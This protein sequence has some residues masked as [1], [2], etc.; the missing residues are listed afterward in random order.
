MALTLEDLETPTRKTARQEELYKQAH[1]QTNY[2]GYDV[3]NAPC[4]G[5][6]TARGTAV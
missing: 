1:L 3:L 6:K 2:E 5:H 4:F